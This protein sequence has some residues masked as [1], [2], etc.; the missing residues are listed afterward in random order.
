MP[1]CNLS[2]V[3]RK[4]GNATP[5]SP[6]QANDEMLLRSSD[7]VSTRRSSDLSRKVKAI[8]KNDN[9]ARY[10]T[11]VACELLLTIGLSQL[12]LEGLLNRTIE[13]CA[14]LQNFEGR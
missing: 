3:Q 12:L 8:Q 4:V 10:K 2:A 5:V 14:S 9:D 6:L 13:A 11:Q 1:V 7:R